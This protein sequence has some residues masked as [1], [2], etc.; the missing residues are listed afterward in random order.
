MRVALFVTNAA[1][2]YGG[3]RLAAFLLAHCLA[4]AGAEVSFVTNAKP[5]FYEDLKYFGHPGKVG[6]YLTKDFHAGLPEG[7]FDVVIIIPG[8]SQD[9]QFYI[10][11]R[12]FAKRRGARLA[13]FNFETPNW[14]NSFSPTPRSE[15]MW[16][17]W[18][19]CIEDGC[20]V[21]S[22]SAQSMHWA[23]AYY[24]AYPATT[25][26]D[27]WHQPIN[28]QAL[29]RVAPQYREK[30]VVCFVRARDPHKGGQD[31]IDALSADLAGWTLSLI[32][33]SAKLDEEYREAILAAARRY[34][35]G[36]EVKPLLSDVDKF[37]EL[38]RA[39]MLLYPSL[40][41][42]YGIPPIEALS[43]GTP[44][45]CYDLPVFREVC[46]DALIASPAGDIDGLRAGIRRVIA[47]Q[48]EDW[49]GLPAA[50][51]AVGSIEA[52]GQAALNSLTRYLHQTVPVALPVVSPPRGNRPNPALVHIDNARLDPAGFVEIQ[53]WSPLRERSRLV[54]SV[55]GQV[56]GE[57]TGG[58]P[59]QDVLEQHPWVGTPDSGFVLCR[60]FVPAAA[61]FT[62]TVTALGP[63]G[64]RFDSATQVFVTAE[65]RKPAAKPD[66]LLY[67]R[68][69]VKCVREA[70]TAFVQGW[71]A[72]AAPILAMEAFVDGRPVWLQRGR[73]RP[74]VMAKLQTFPEQAPG[75][76]AHLTAEQTLGLDVAKEMVLVTTTAAGIFMERIKLKLEEGI[77]GVAELLPDP[78][79][80]TDL[81]ALPLAAAV[82]K[83]TYDEYGVVEFEGWVLSNPRIDVMKFYLGDAFLG[84]AVPDRLYN[85]IFEKNRAYGDAFCGFHFAGRAVGLPPADAP[86]RVELCYGDEPA[87]TITGIAT[88]SRRAEAALSSDAA[89]WPK[90]FLTSTTRPA[91][92]CAVVEDAIWLDPVAGA[93]P[94][95]MLA[96]LRQSGMDILLLLHGNPHRF[97]DELGRWQA[98]A[99]AVIL[100]NPLSPVPDAAPLPHAAWNRSS[101]ALEATLAGLAEQMPRLAAVLVQ[102]PSIAPALM[103]V[104]STVPAGPLPLVLADPQAPAVPW[105]IA[106]PTGTLVVGD[107]PQGRDGIRL[108][109]DV[110]GLAA[111]VVPV[112]DADMARSSWLILNGIGASPAVLAQASALAAEAASLAGLRLGVVVDAAP[113]EPV[114]SIRSRLGLPE[115]AQ[116]IWLSQLAG[117]PR[118]VVRAMLDLGIGPLGAVEAVA[119][120]R[121]VNI[122]LWRVL[123]PP[124]TQR[125]WQPQGLVGMLTASLPAPPIEGAPY[126]ALDAA[127]RA[128]APAPSR[129]LA[130]E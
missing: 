129:L 72:A 67:Q 90:D 102:H 65:K 75:F 124:G 33:G 100:V 70:E 4:R 45:V 89:L 106:C 120:N 23:Q 16:L 91:V 118:G 15:D 86:Y 76:T 113:L 14:F 25:S 119:L 36:I 66:P 61:E 17:E 125:P 98:L 80:G 59:R 5:V 46:G 30:R 21:L 62:V 74:D 82:R 111:Q 109:F 35:I 107:M 56:L 43:A 31:L 123:A 55:D 97:A 114:A 44:C 20:L 127:L 8:Q 83:V 73:T 18:R 50:V 26:F 92:F 77:G 128:K 54:V 117:L 71:V 122:G 115:D 47:S 58:L 87:R 99:D 27:Y 81:N 42:G 22:N 126:A 37:V 34:Q 28:V 13:L 69:G 49:A 64:T 108:G 121:G 63:D 84:E 112:G 130:A 48:P 93:G 88:P 68:G 41:E 85:N 24:T 101:P 53:G 79:A 10:G 94:R 2:T 1:G 96:H 78:E 19:R 103:A 95:A 32:V 9:R 12:G 104:A 105:R 3:G 11:A 57:V 116:P 110:A 38:K 51:A 7:G 6:V 39:R 60:P 40:F 29:A 52:C